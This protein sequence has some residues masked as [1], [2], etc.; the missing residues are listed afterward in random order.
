MA[1]GVISCKKSTKTLKKS[2]SD[3][4]TVGEFYSGQGL[5]GGKGREG[6]EGEGRKRKEDVTMAD[7]T[8]NNN[9]ER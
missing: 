9:K 8:T 5:G 2:K 1:Y 3:L 7:Q 4:N 6:G